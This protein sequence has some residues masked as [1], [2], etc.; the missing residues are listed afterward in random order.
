MSHLDEVI[1]HIEVIRS[2]I[3]SKNI[4]TQTGDDLSALALELSSLKSYLGEEE[5][6]LRRSYD[7]L[8]LSYDLERERVFLSNREAGKSVADS[9]S[10]KRTSTS[11]KRVELIG[12]R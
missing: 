1:S 12:A 4:R 11:E 7:E 3:S 9:D 2:N 6:K 10:A 5:A 8:E